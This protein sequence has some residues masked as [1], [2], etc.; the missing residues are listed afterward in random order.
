MRAAYEG[1]IVT[2]GP[3]FAALGVDDWIEFTPDGHDI[4]WADPGSCA[5]SALGPQDPLSGNPG[6]VQG[7]A[8]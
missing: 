7:S 2:A 6:A 8:A 4:S 5:E 3:S 1:G